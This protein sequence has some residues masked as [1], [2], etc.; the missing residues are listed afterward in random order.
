L[1]S[2]RQGYTIRVLPYH[3]DQ[4]KALLPGAITWA[5]GHVK[6]AEAVFQPV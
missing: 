3:R 5:D 2:G 1:K 6:A 4:T